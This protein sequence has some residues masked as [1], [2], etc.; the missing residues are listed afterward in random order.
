[1]EEF[2]VSIKG[3]NEIIHEKSSINLHLHILHIMEY[4][5]S[6]KV[7]QR[8][9]AGAV[10]KRLFCFCFFSL[11]LSRG[12]FLSINVV[13]KNNWISINASTFTL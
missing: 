9:S 10:L 8:I 2:T 4:K 5:C 7:R 1:M 6:I 12:G 3:K 11:V 13:P